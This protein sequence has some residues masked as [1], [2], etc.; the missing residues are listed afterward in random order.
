V[1][2][3]S[4]HIACSA[5]GYADMRRWPLAGRFRDL[6]VTLSRVG[7]IP[8]PVASP[9]SKRAW[10]PDNDDESV[11]QSSAA[12]QPSFPPT[13]GL[14]PVPQRNTPT[15][16]SFPSTSRTKHGISTFGPP[17]GTRDNHAHA[18]FGSVGTGDLFSAPLSGGISGST[19]AFPS[20]GLSSHPTPDTSLLPLGS[21]AM[22][23]TSPPNSFRSMQGAA[24]FGAQTAHQHGPYQPV[25]DLYSL[26]GYQAQASTSGMYS[27]PVS[28][29]T[30]APAA[31]DTPT[32]PSTDASPAA[33]LG[34]GT[35][36]YGQY[37]GGP[38]FDPDF[39]PAR[40]TPD[41]GGA[42]ELMNFFAPI[43]PQDGQMGVGSEM[44]NMWSA[45][46]MTYQCASSSFRVHS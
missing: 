44:F 10:H 25:H 8:L 16:R 26:F 27:T 40:A 29:P 41:M 18:A 33:T 34:L 19:T 2:K 36:L 9:T 38:V 45:M 14:A 37:S 11:P 32:P 12:T 42:D 15:S 43:L 35:D 6:L 5:V 4:K 1:A 24:G 46:P 21:A 31:Y 17:L 20:A 13:S 23:H 28:P 3:K 39:A 30:S 7:D 22:S